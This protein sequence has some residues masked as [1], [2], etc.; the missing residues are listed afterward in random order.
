MAKK[1]TMRAFMKWGKPDVNEKARQVVWM[2]DGGG[3][4]KVRR[5]A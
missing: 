2:K 4:W 1:N 3:G 5:S